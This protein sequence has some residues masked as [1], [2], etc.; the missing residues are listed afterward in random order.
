MSLLSVQGVDQTNRFLLSLYR[1]A[2]RKNL[3]DLP[4][5]KARM[6]WAQVEC[7]DDFY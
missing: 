4:M 7:L 2:T 1:H 6:S 3:L 5:T